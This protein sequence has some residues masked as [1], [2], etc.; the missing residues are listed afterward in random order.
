MLTTPSPLRSSSRNNARVRGS[1][2]PPNAAVWMRVA[3]LAIDAKSD[4]AADCPS[5][6]DTAD[7][8]GSFASVAADVPSMSKWA[9]NSCSV[10]TRSPSLSSFWKSS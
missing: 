6:E 1:M 8:A 7:A 10:K 2:P 4:V 3:E 9:A 5:K